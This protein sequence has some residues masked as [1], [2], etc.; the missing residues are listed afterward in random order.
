MVNISNIYVSRQSKDRFSLA[1]M[2]VPPAKTSKIIPVLLEKKKRPP[3]LVQG[4][5]VQRILIK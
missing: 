3:Y 4:F 1:P 2:H 5:L